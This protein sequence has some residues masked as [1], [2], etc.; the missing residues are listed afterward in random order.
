VI[1]TE[2]ST[3]MASQQSTETSLETETVTSG[4]ETSSTETSSV[5]TTQAGTGQS[6]LATEYSSTAEGEKE[7]LT[8][9][10]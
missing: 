4:V 5:S 3:T 6:I 9:K 10:N 8:K 1:E 7:I 2:A